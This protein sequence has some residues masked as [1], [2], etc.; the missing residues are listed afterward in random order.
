MGLRINS[1]R[2]KDVIIAFLEHYVMRK[3][4]GRLNHGK[5]A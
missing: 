5:R 2:D 1:V 4:G 3:V